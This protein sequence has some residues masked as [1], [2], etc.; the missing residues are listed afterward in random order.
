MANRKFNQTLGPVHVGGGEFDRIEVLTPYN[1]ITVTN[2]SFDNPMVATIA[3]GE[4]P[5]DPQLGGDGHW[6]IPDRQ[7]RTL[8]AAPGV[9]S[10]RL[11]IVKVMGT[12]DDGSDYLADG[13]DI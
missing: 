2:L 7:Q 8:R 1:S 13:S 10:N 3:V 6:N 12:G 9:I 11:P 4:E 5:P